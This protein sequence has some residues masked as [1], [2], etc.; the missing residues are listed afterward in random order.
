MKEIAIYGAGGLGREIACL[1]RHINKEQGDRWNLIGF[2]DDGLVPGV[3]NDYGTIIGGIEELNR[4]PTPLSVVIAIASPAILTTLVAKIVNPNVSF[5]NI[6][7]PNVFFFDEES[8]EMGRGNILTFNCRVSCN[9]KIGNFNIFNGGV[10]L[11]HDITIGDNNVFMP[12]T[13]L[14]GGV[15]VGCNNFF[16]ARSF[17]MQQIKI[18]NSTTVG[19]GSVIMRKTKDGAT[20][21]G[22]PAKKIEIS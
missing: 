1:L 16:G 10:S 7:A 21:I 22:N 13:R 12:E 11:G 4:Y 14:S 6:V 9:V 17:V 20:Y 3:S 19:V 18:G 5:P 8:V 2:F 15:S